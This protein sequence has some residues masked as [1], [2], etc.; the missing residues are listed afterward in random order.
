MRI[1]E[2]T[3]SN[4]YATGAAGSASHVD[5]QLRTGNSQGPELAASDSA[6]LSGAAN[7]VALARQITSPGRS[8]RVSGIIAQVQAGQYRADAQQVGEAV[9]RGHLNG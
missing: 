4:V 8:A 2:N 6:Q 5:G 9:V 1:E 3:A 7:W